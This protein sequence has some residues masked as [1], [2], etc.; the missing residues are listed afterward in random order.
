[1][2]PNTPNEIE[3]KEQL[4]DWWYSVQDLLA[5]K[6][7]CLHE[8]KRVELEKIFTQLNANRTAEMEVARKEGYATGYAQCCADNN[9]MTH[10]QMQ[11]E[12]DTIN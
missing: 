6:D 5:E 3:A 12:L 8:R 4:R 7:V 9:L 2:P 10:E 1:M 11:D